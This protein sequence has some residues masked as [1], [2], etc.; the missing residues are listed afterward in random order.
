MYNV[1]LIKFGGKRYFQCLYSGRGGGG[2]GG[3]CIVV[4]FR[5]SVHSLVRK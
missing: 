2:R 4:L 5:T 3:V 1:D